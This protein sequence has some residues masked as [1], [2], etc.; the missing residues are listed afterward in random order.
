LIVLVIAVAVFG[1]GRLAGIGAALGNSVRDFRKA[2][3]EDDAPVDAKPALRDGEVR[4]AHR[5]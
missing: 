3:K 4:E 2:V 1:A 5:Q